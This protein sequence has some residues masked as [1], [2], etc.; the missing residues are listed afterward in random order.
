MRKAVAVIAVVMALAA[1]GMAQVGTVVTG[2][3]AP[4]DRISLDNGQ[5]GVIASVDLPCGLWLVSGGVTT[6]VRVDDP[7]LAGHYLYSFAAFTDDP[8]FVPSNGTIVPDARPYVTG[9][10]SLTPTTFP[11][12]VD[13]YGNQTKTIYLVVVSYGQVPPL[14]PESFGSINA[15]QI[16]NRY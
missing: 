16:P 2:T 3:R 14:L 9:W 11:F 8:S 6:Q 4:E 12:L 1:S 7:S 13:V 15:V 5:I 10:F